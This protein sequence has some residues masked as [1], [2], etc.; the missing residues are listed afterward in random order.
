MSPYPPRRWTAFLAF[1]LAAASLGAA[2]A[3]DAAAQTTAV[4]VPAYRAVGASEPMISP[5]QNGTDYSANRASLAGLTL[6]ATIPAPSEPRRG[7]IVQ[8]QCVAGLTVVLDDQNSALAATLIVLG[9]A[10]TDGGQGGSIDMSG[11]PHTGR[12]RIYSKNAACQMA[13]RSW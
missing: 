10:G 8:A 7:Y 3:I 5:G 13:A 9:G 12:I 11:V 1:V 2:F 4:E 6:L